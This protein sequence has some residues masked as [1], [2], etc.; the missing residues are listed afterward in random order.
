[1]RRSIPVLPAIVEG[2]DSFFSFELSHGTGDPLLEVIA[3]PRLNTICNP[4]GFAEEAD[5][6]RPSG[7]AFIFSFTSRLQVFTTYEEAQMANSVKPQVTVGGSEG[8]LRLGEF[9]IDHL[10]DLL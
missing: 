9:V 1:M 7:G 4:D 2:I 5:G 6:R 10:H 3:E 8:K